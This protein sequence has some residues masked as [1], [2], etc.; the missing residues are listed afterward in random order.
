MKSAE[1]LL[2]GRS[3]CCSSGMSCGPIFVEKDPQ[4]KSPNA[5]ASWEYDANWRWDPKKITLC[6]PAGAPVRCRRQ[7]PQTVL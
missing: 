1:D 5:L 2:A 3:V 6:L 4:L 7:G